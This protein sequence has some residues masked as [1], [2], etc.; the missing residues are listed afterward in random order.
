[1]RIILPLLSLDLH[2]YRKEDSDAPRV[3]ETVAQNNAQAVVFNTKES[4]K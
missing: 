2:A 4:S 1:M 3:V